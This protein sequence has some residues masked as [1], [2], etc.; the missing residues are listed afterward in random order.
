MYAS[1]QLQGQLS[2]FFCWL[3][4]RC[5]KTKDLLQSALP[6]QQLLFFCFLLYIPKGRHTKEY[7]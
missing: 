2:A 6:W 4:G 1:K 7:M 3:R 5:A